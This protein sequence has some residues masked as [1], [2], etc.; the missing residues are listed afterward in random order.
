MTNE[1][2]QDYTY[3]PETL[4][5][6]P[7]KFEGKPTQLLEDYVFSTDGA[8]SK[9]GEAGESIENKTIPNTEAEVK[10]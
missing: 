3:N 5:N 9:W 4:E 1:F 8:R 7:G 2:V 6:I 10:A